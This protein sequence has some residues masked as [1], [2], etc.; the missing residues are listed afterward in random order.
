LSLSL[1]VLRRSGADERRR[2]LLALDARVATASSSASIEGLV[3]EYGDVLNFLRSLQAFYAQQ[4]SLAALRV[5]LPHFDILC[6]GDR[7]LTV[8]VRLSPDFREEWH[9]YRFSPTRADIRAFINTLEVSLVSVPL[10][11]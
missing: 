1:S 8:E 11:T 10:P 5:A 9:V 6:T 3:V 7:S 2:A 4:E